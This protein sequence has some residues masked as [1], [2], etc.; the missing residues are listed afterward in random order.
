M[1]DD[2]YGAADEALA[3]AA[4]RTGDFGPAERLYHQAITAARDPADEARA[5]GG[6]G[7]TRHYRNIAVLLDGGTVPDDD[8]DAEDD[9]MRRSLELWQTTGDDAGTASGMFG[10]G[11]V[12]Q[13]LRRD[14]DS[15]MHYYWQAFGLVE[16]V[17]DSGDLYGCSEIHRH[18]GFYYLVEDVR[19]NEAV[20][21]LQRSLDLREQL[22]DPRRIPSGLVA[23]GEAE[24]AAGNRERAVGLLGHAVRAAR[25]ADLLPGRIRDAEDALH[26]A[27]G[28]H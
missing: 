5:T 4:F 22:G 3:E 27:Q 8:I 14:W 13:V 21:R 28:Q 9:I 12:W 7:M 19:P 20:R 2:L 6:L 17:E 26:E 11:L 10:V 25:E 24:L 16:A 23:L 1:N 15:A 18:I